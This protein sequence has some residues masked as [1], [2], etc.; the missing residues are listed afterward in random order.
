M[1]VSSLYTSPSAPPLSSDGSIYIIPRLEQ[2]TGDLAYHLTFVE[3]L[4]LC[5]EG[6]NVATEIRCHSFLPLDELVRIVRHKDC[7]PEVFAYVWLLHVITS[8]HT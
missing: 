5:T 1:S 3:L 4:T 6:K 8:P 2:A 7:I